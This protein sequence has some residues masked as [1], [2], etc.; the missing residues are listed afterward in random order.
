MFE[1]SHLQYNIVSGNISIVSDGHQLPAFWAHPELGGPFPG[2][3]LL[4]DAWGVTA[5][6][7]AQARRFAEQGYYVIAP[8]LFNRQG[9]DSVAEAQER[10]AHMGGVA[11]A[12]LVAALN[13]LRTHHK[14]NGT[15]G[16]IGWGISGELAL[17]AAILRDDL[18]AVVTFYAVPQDV[19]PAELRMMTTPLLVIIGGADPGTPRDQVQ[20]LGDVLAS[21]STEHGVVIFEGSGRDFFNDARAEFN[22]EA[23]EGAWTRAL[24]FLNSHLQESDSAESAETEEGDEPQ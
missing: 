19:T 4:H 6:I 2:L 17:R 23:A 5:H 13:A 9:F 18:G 16:I 11:H 8:D 20:A 15:M 24:G 3:V 12:Y 14:C 1:A 7:R 21:V 10:M 22:P